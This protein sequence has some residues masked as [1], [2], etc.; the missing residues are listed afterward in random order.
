MINPGAKGWINKYFHLVEKGIIK[1]DLP[2]RILPEKR[3]FMHYNFAKTGIVYGYPL[4]FIFYKNV[5]ANHWTMDEK[6]RLL[7]LECHLFTYLLEN[8][9]K[10]V[11]HEFIDELYDFYAQHDANS[12]PKLFQKFIKEHTKENR[13]EKILAKRSDISQRY[14]HKKV[15]VSTMSNA[16]SFLDVILFDEYLFQNKRKAIKNYGAYAKNSMI[17]IILS[18]NSD[19]EIQKSESAIFS[20]FLSSADLPHHI[21]NDLKKLFSNGANFDY[22][23][24]KFLDNW[25]LKHFILDISILTVISNHDIVPEESNFLERLCT[26]LEI[27][28]LEFENSLN[29]AESFLFVTEHEVQH[30]LKS[31]TYSKTVRGLSRRWSKILHRNKNKIVQEIT[32]SK[33]L[34]LLLRKSQKETLTPTEKKIIKNQLTDILKSFPALVI[35]MIPGGSLLLP[36]LLKILPDFLPS[37]FRENDFDS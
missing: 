14:H 8:K 23:D 35:F 15:W 2:E 3:Q 16:L 4:E 13:I 28:S 10:F 37:S 33:E 25:L 18:A 19:G 22:F 26:F 24:M 34:V 17:S 27:D 29:Y 32:E 20:I 31:S 11:S 36:V 9:K 5:D 7:L 21:N 12:L 30:F 6:M 1:L